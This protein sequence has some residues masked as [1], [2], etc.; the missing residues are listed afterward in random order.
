ML[1]NLS[2]TYI[3]NTSLYVHSQYAVYNGV[4]MLG[5]KLC[6]NLQNLILKFNTLCGTNWTL[7]K[8]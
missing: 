2:Y 6:H 4:F 1:L 5:I 7:D 8:D 3:H